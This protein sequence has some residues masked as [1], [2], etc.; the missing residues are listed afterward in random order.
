LSQSFESIRRSMPKCC[1]IFNPS[2]INREFREEFSPRISR[3]LLFGCGY[4]F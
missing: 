3:I 4:S 1:G 2:A